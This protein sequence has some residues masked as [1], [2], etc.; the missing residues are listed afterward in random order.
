MRHFIYILIIGIVV[1]SCQSKTI[2]TQEQTRIITLTIDSALTQDSGLN[3]NDYWI[4][5]SKGDFFERQ[6]IEH[7]LKLR[8][9]FNE[10]NSDSLLLNDS[11]WIQ[12]GYLEKMLIRITKVEFKGDSLIIDLETIKATD[13]SNGIPT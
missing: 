13:G 12:Y 1:V 7:F 3:T 10:I 5:Y 2:T 6:S 8:T 4:D 9:N 11:T